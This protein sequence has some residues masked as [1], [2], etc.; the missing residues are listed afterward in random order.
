M[1]P[2]ILWFR[3]DLRLDY[4]LAL[5]AAVGSKSPIIPVYGILKIQETDR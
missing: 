5:E 2:V 3:R 1:K 4:N